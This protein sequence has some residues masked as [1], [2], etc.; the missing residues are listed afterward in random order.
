MGRLQTFPLEFF[1]RIF[2]IRAADVEHSN[3]RY[4][5][6]VASG[7]GLNHIACSA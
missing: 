1:I 2:Q 7:A 5:L 4:L 3:F 6:G